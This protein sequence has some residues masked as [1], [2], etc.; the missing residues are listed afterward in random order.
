M[1]PPHLEKL[2]AFDLTDMFRP[3][4]FSPCAILNVN[5]TTIPGFK[6]TSLLTLLRKSG[7]AVQESRTD[8]QMLK[9]KDLLECLRLIPNTST[10][11]FG[12]LN[13][14]FLHAFLHSSGDP[15]CPK[16]KS[17]AITCQLELNDE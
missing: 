11:T 2:H 4:I 1:A 8:P 6:K 13:K 3:L 9:V 17:L 10:L 16:L 14:S 5:H 12:R 15:L 7:G